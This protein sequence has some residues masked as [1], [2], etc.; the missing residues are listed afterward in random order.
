MRF[1]SYSSIQLGTVDPKQL[2]GVIKS[3]KKYLPKERVRTYYGRPVIN[4]GYKTKQLLRLRFSVGRVQIIIGTILGINYDDFCP[5]YDNLTQA[6]I[7]IDMESLHRS[8][9]YPGLLDLVHPSETMKF[10]IDRANNMLIV[11]EHKS[12]TCIKILRS[13]E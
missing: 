8:P 6:D 13:Y 7:I 11:K 1:L 5:L 12:T 10:F 4:W 2:L 3:T 9:K